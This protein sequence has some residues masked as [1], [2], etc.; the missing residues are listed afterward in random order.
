M[1][2]TW[3]FLSLALL[4]LSCVSSP[5]AVQ[6]RI[7]GRIDSASRATLRGQVHPLV[8][9]AQDEG[10]VANA[11]LLPR[12]ML[13][14]KRTAAQQAD[15]DTLLAQ[16]QD[17]SSP[18][19][20]KWLTP[21][22]FADRFGLS[23]ADLGQVENWL[24]GQGFRIV[25]APQSRTYIAVSGTAA[26]VQAAF[27][28]SIH[29][30]AV[31]GRLHYANATDP[32]LPAALADVV[33]GIHGLSDFRPR[34]QGVAGRRI[35]A[36]FTSSIS[37][38]HFLAPDD[39]ATI[40][41]LKPLYDQGIDGTGQKI[42]VMGQTDLVMSD[43]QA[44][45]S[46]S[47][48]PANNPQV[49]LVPGSKDPGVVTGDLDEANLDVEWAGAV[50]RNAT[51][52]FVNSGNGAFDS[53][54]YAISQNIAPVVSISY[55]DCEPNWT[56]ADLN[57]LSASAQQAN[58]QGMTIVGPTGDTGAAD[59]DYSTSPNVQVTIARNGLTVDVPASLPYVT[60]VGGTR[61]NEGNGTYW[62]STNNSSN[63]S[64]LSYIPEVGWNDTAYELAN[65]GSL[66]ASGGGASKVFSKPSWQ[67]GAGVPND[68]ARDVPD[69]AFAAS[70]DSDGYLIC[71][72][73][74]CVNGYRAA[75]STLN[76][77]GGTSAGA[78]VFAG[79]VALINQKSQVSQGNVNPRLYQLAS[80]SSDAFHDVQSGDN[81]V[82]CAIGTT[83]CP[84]GGQIGYT[85]GVGYDLVTGLGSI[86]TYNL[87]MEWNESSVTPS[88]DFQLSAASSSLT[89][90]SSSPATDSIAVT[91]Q[92]GFSGAVSLTC[93]MPASL[94]NATCTVSP[95][96]VTGSGTVV[97]T[98]AKSASTAALRAPAAWPR[99]WPWTGG[100]LALAFGLVIG[101]GMPK[102]RKKMLALLFALVLVAV[103]AMAGCGG[104][105]GSPATPATTTT[106][107][108]TSA[109]TTGAVAVQA[110]SG[111][112][113][114][115]TQVSVT[116]Q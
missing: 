47:G 39:F 73:G 51:I 87:V 114:H 29:H 37:G 68:G 82:P 59:C 96:S 64:A 63:G 99:S 38:S 71:S 106:A 24:T 85:A 52:I 78:P 83:D 6:N 61:L 101:E 75:D 56:T 54:Q 18:N 109:S 55:G 14:F 5:A 11:T 107:P 32:S 108:A 94:S 95:N 43:I 60:S 70:F 116:V 20:H 112:I 58:A 9:S 21:Q 3:K 74:S 110:T 27:Q 36:D 33:L 19:F 79:L 88:P 45:R 15:L 100:G 72:Q 65:G 48:L 91:A 30:Y 80:A 35:K 67:T 102:S 28:T 42:A 26:Q 1:L 105:T 44:F 89:A 92:N 113:T 13:M 4:V 50:A 66:S 76:V 84:N 115:T 53:L 10:Q 62:N 23:Q 93:I 57:S 90:T 103:L 17:P 7:T 25:E 12:I 69:V 40:Y 34:P 104:S 81:M 77:V 46:A 41:N 16:Q 22:Q 86:N 98:V 31:N 2:R 8:R 111:S 97:L 49:V